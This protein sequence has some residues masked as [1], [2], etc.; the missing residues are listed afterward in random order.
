M[1]AETRSSR[2]RRDAAAVAVVV[3]GA[4][5]W[6]GVAFGGGAAGTANDRGGAAKA[7]RAAKAAKRAHVAHVQVR[8]HHDGQCP[9]ADGGGASAQ[10]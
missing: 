4:A 2:W 6:A 5:V 7:P 3:A 10:L 9:F 1:D 8:A